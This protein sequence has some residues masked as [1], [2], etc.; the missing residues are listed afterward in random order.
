MS[1]RSRSSVWRANPDRPEH[2]RSRTNRSEPGDAGPGPA[3]EPARACTRE[4]GP[5]H[6]SGWSSTCSRYGGAS[7][8]NCPRLGTPRGQPP[9][10]DAESGRARP[11]ARGGPP[12]RAVPIRAARQARYLVAPRPWDVLLQHVTAVRASTTHTCRSTWRRTGRARV[13]QVWHAVG[14]AEAV[15]SGH[16]HAGSASRNGPS[17]TATTTSWSVPARRRAGRTRPP[18]GPGRACPSPRRRRGPTFLRSRR[19]W[20]RRAGGPDGVPACAAVRGWCSTPRRSAGAGGQS[21]RLPASMPSRSGGPAGG[22]RPR[23]ESR[24]PTSIRRWCR[25]AGYDVV[26][27]R[28]EINEVLAAHGR[29]RH[30]LLVLDL[31][32]GTPAPPDIVLLTRTSPSTSAIPG[33]TW[34]LERS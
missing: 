24:I 15:W 10:I 27:D 33:C 19:P 16:A 31:R 17:S 30:R 12:A 18:S 21:A 20:P 11:R 5:A 8:R 1:S 2:H 7:S 32:V 22:P 13:V 14:R 25:T 9:Y 3:D 29:P 34:M 23:P 26:V 6:P 28:A 4:P